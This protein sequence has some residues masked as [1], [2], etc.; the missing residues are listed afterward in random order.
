MENFFFAFLDELGHLEAKKRIVE[1][2]E[3]DGKSE[4]PS[5]LFLSFF[6]APSLTLRKLILLKT[7]KTPLVKKIFS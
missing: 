7:S 6:P 3:N 2:M 4:P 1:M 5:F